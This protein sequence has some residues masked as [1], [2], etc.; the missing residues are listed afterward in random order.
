MKEGYISEKIL[1]KDVAGRVSVTLRVDSYKDLNPEFG[2]DGITVETCFEE[3]EGVSY[4]TTTFRAVGEGGLMSSITTY[5]VDTAKLWGTKLPKEFLV[6]RHR[7]ERQDTREHIIIDALG[8]TSR[9]ETVVRKNGK[10]LKYS[11]TS[12]EERKRISKLFNT[13]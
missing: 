10:V 13:V 12:D 6:V 2:G 5:R 8:F 11:K 3:R 9:V 1:P 4:K 7:L